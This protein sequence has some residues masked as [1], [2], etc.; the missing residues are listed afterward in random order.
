MNTHR[1]TIPLDSCDKSLKKK[2]LQV[3][4]IFINISNCKRKGGKKDVQQH[5]GR[6]ENDGTE[7]RVLRNGD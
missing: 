4:T 6:A 7:L 1:N 2:A 5:S 3:E